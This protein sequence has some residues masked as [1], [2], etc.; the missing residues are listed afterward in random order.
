MDAVGK[1]VC[2]FLHDSALDQVFAE[3]LWSFL[4][5]GLTI[6]AYDRMLFGGNDSNSSGG[7]GSDLQEPD[8]M[9]LLFE[10]HGD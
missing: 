7:S 2:S 3:Q 8:G 1:A 10:E 6:A 4:H 5:S 9:Q